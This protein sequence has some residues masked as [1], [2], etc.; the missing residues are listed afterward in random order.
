MFAAV[1]ATTMCHAYVHL[2]CKLKSI[3]KI[4]PFFIRLLHWLCGTLAG[5]KFQKIASEMFSG[6]CIYARK[7]NTELQN[8]GTYTD[9]FTYEKCLLHKAYAIAK[10]SFVSRFVWKYHQ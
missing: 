10:M 1:L 8:Q 4:S 3:N 6:Q 5:R 7:Q 9:I 2:S